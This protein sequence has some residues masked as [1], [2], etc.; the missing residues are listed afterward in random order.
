MEL[1]CDNCFN[2]NVKSNSVDLIIAD[3]PY[4]NAVNNWKSELDLNNLWKIYKDI[5]KPNG[6]VIFFC[7]GNFTYEVINSNTEMYRYKLIWKKNCPLGMRTAYREPMKYY[8]E[9]LVF[10]KN[11]DAT[12]NPILSTKNSFGNT[13]YTYGNSN[14]E[15]LKRHKENRN[16]YVLPSDIIEFKVVP[17]RCGRYHPLQKPVDILEYLIKTYSNEGDV[18][19]DGCMGSGSTGVAALNTNRDF[20]GIEIDRKYFN[21][22]KKRLTDK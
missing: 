2:V 13:V 15:E 21:L 22:A 16:G 1:Y 18:V 19:Y 12:Y 17:T 20:V 4:G 6:N 5:L 7:N 9:I 14:E 8:E 11:Q 10:N 3:L